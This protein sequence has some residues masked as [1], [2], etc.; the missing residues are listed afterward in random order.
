MKKKSKKV[1]VGISG[2]VDSSVSLALLKER[3]YSPIGIFMKFWG[4]ENNCCGNESERRARQICDQLDVPFY[5][6]DARSEFKKEVV[7][8]FLDSYKKGNTPNPCV[9]CNKKIKFKL[10]FEKINE[11]G[12]ELIATGHYVNKK[13]GTLL[14]PKD[15]QKDQTYF[16][17]DLPKEYIENS[18]FPL[19]KLT[20]KEVRKKARKLNLSTANVSESQEV[21]FVKKGLINFLDKHIDLEPGPIVNKNGKKLGR[22][23]GLPI[24]TIGQRKGIG[25][26]GGPYYVLK[27]N[28]DKNELIVT[29]NN[30]DLKASDVFFENQ[31]F[32]EKFEYPLEVKAKIRYNALLREGVLKEDYFRFNEAQRAIASGQSIVFYKDDK[33]LGGGII[34]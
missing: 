28:I 9:V 34:K 17:W 32:F 2:G 4:K 15:R 6:L 14:R 7:D 12:G 10:L 16:L 21:C 31:N 13:D 24:Y 1:A 25:L 8:Y 20:K 29:K 22:H 23:K 19:G 33:L 3:G 5:T 30:K 11:F 26:S 27:K 18:L